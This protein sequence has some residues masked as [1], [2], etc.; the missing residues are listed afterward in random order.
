VD[1]TL[2]ADQRAL[3]AGLRDYLQD[4]WTPAA[5]APCRRTLHCDGKD[6]RTLAELGIFGLSLPEAA[7]GTDWAWPMS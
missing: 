3:R 6:W 7:G 4:T 2:S 5:P 1:L